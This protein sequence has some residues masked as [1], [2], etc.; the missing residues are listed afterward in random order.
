M[1]RVV[2]PLLQRYAA[3]TGAVSVV[4]PPVQNVV[5]PVM[6]PGLRSVTTAGL[7]VVEHP[8]VVTSTLYEPGWLT[9]IDCVV[10]PF[11]HA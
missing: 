5:P 11:D 3:A 1:E 9:V 7:D 6:L 10:C 4:E 8:P 2:A